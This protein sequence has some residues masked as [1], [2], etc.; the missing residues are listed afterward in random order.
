MDPTSTASEVSTIRVRE[1]RHGDDIGT[2]R[3]GD[4]SL[5][6]NES[7]GRSQVTVGFRSSMAVC[8][9]RCF[10]VSVRGCWFALRVSRADG[11]VV[12]AM[13]TASGLSV[14]VGSLNHSNKGRLLFSAGSWTE[15]RRCAGVAHEL[16]RNRTQCLRGLCCTFH[17]VGNE[18]D[19][20]EYSRQRGD[21]VW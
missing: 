16:L 10:D 1:D 5:R 8:L 3:V 7:E 15:A 2:C 6:R 11:N 19:I 4:E 13:A 18:C 12:V 21:L 9:C 17:G 14:L 20:G